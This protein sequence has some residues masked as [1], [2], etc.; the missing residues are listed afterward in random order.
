[1]VQHDPLGL[2]RP[3]ERRVDA[4]LDRATSLASARNA[5]VHWC[6]ASRG[7][8]MASLLVCNVESELVERPRRGVRA[9][10]RSVEAEHRAVPRAAL[11]PRRTGRDLLALIRPGSGL[12]LDPDTV[13]SAEIGRPADLDG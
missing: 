12:D 3:A 11:A 5:S 7:P 10:G 4:D 13:R 6:G 1:M 2:D 9:H 8:P